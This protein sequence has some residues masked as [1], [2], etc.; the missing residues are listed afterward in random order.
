MAKGKMNIWRKFLCL[1]VVFCFTLLIACQSTPGQEI[2]VNKSDGAVGKAIAAS[3]APITA[4]DSPA[5]WT[6]VVQGYQNTTYEID[7]T[8][9]VPNVDKFPVVEVVPSMF[10]RE[11]LDGITNALFPDC[12]ISLH[13]PNLLTKADIQ[14]YINGCLDSIANVDKY[15]PEFSKEQRE[16][17]IAEYEESFARW[18]EE[19]KTA[20]EE[21]SETQ[22][23]S[24]ADVIG[25]EKWV[26]DF[27]LKNQTKK[28]GSITL[29]IT[30]K[31]EWDQRLTKLIVLFNETRKP[32]STARI[33]IHNHAEVRRIAEQL[34]SQ[35]PLS[36][37]TF[38]CVYRDLN[39]HRD[40]SIAIFT[41]AYGGIQTGYI[42]EHFYTTESQDSFAMQWDQEMIF[43]PVGPQGIGS[44]V[45]TSSS[46]EGNMLNENVTLLPFSKI[47]ELAMTSFSYVSLPWMGS[48]PPP[49]DYRAVVDEIKLSMMV[50]K[51]QD[52]A[53]NYMAIP[54]W[55][56]YGYWYE[57]YESQEKSGRMLDENLE[58]KFDD[59]PGATSLLT[60]S[61][62]DGSIVNRS[63][64]Y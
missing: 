21:A 15:H 20:P 56:F 9:T 6:E 16:A 18:Q 42:R 32:S 14:G 44:F 58:Y 60:L 29:N 43:V 37:Y 8:I 12:A 51:M 13:D 11:Q 59:Y 54:V 28:L 34:V 55:D 57:R 2:I 63:A 36:E 3:P 62:I 35:L 61:A 10:T 40:S 46:A 30:P 50:V 26:Y 5:Y 7:A 47:Q 22:V 27:E 33:D 31:S 19:Y 23:E 45:W 39:A 41:K 1:A 52:S 49:I 25:S 64:G 4:Y 53:D 17:Y 24:I 38:S 48:E